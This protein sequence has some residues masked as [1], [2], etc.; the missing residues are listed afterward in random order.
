MLTDYL[1]VANA[2]VLKIRFRPP[3]HSK[4][5][6]LKWQYGSVPLRS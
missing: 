4:R 6:A 2:K 1:E 3:I 5:W